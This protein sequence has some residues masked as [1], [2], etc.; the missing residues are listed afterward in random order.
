[1]QAEITVIISPALGKNQWPQPH[2]GVR[3]YA[4]RGGGVS[5]CFCFRKAPCTPFPA[6]DSQ[7]LPEV[8]PTLNGDLKLPS[9]AQSPEYF[10]LHQ[11]I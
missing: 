3:C 2:R 8:V 1:M 9:F 11:M 4:E 5:A 10:F 6:R 7:S